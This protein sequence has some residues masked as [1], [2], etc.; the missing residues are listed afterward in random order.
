[1]RTVLGSADLE[2]FQGA[3]SLWWAVAVATR[4]GLVIPWNP[5]RCPEFLDSIPLCKIMV[6]AD[7]TWCV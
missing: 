7:G 1:M 4:Q 6:F 3:C 5:T 2:G